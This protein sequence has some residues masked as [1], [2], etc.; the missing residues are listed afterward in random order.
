MRVRPKNVDPDPALP[1]RIAWRQQAVC[2]GLDP[3]MFVPGTESDDTV[4]DA[5]AV[6]AGCPVR[7]DCLAEALADPRIVGVWG[8]TTTWERREL[9]ADARRRDIS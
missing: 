3:D 6:C 9:R 1:P 2:R 5:V 4:G 8:G 7:L